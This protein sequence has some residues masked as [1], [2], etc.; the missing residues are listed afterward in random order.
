[1]GIYSEK[2]LPW[3]IDPQNVTG[4]ASNRNTG[5]DATHP[6]ANDGERQR[7][8]GRYPDWSG[9]AYNIHYLSDVP[10]NDPVVFNG[11][12]RPGSTIFVSGNGT[13][14]LGKATL[15]TGTVDALVARDRTGTPQHSW[16]VTSGALPTSWT[17]S[18]LLKKRIRFITG[19]NVG[20]T[21][22]PMLEL[23]TKKAKLCAVITALGSSPNVTFPSAQV[24]PSLADQ[25]VVESLVAINNFS[26]YIASEDD[27]TVNTATNGIWLDSLDIGAGAMKA[28][29]ED[30]PCFYGCILHHNNQNNIGDNGRGYTTAM[31]CY[32]MTD[33]G[34]GIVTVARGGVYRFYGGFTD[35]FL[36]V[37]DMAYLQTSS[38]FM[39]QGQQVQIS[40][41]VVNTGGLAVFGATGPG[42]LLIDIGELQN[43]SNLWGDGNSGV[44]LA[45]GTNEAHYNSGN[46][47]TITGSTGDFSVGG[48]TTA[49][50][51]DPLIGNWT[52]PIACTWANLVA[53]LPTGFGGSAMD[54]L[55]GGKIVKGVSV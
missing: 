12:R 53:A 24:T 20:A 16:E 39:V 49:E 40:G 4:L 37:R 22:W 18:S 13:R 51:Y 14:G 30:V 50:A 11:Y 42:V 17:A 5:V 2:Q 7:R 3:Y 21:T 46:V 54:Y 19:A 32:H 44:G 33:N 31:S 47:P 45:S 35:Q 52:A 10:A 29:G 8:V 25:F 55:S 36:V 23:S 15:Y 38:D 27:R 6:I 34:F 1:M 28:V 41:R 26:M 9:G 43:E 48:R